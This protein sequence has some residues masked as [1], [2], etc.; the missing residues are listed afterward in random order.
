[1]YNNI[2]SNYTNGAYTF[3]TLVEAN[4]SGLVEPAY[5]SGLIRLMVNDVLAEKRFTNKFAQ[6]KKKRGYSGKIINSV[7]VNPANG[8]EFTVDG[9]TT[10]F[11]LAPADVKGSISKYT[12]PLQYDTTYNKDELMKAFTSESELTAFLN[13]IISSLY[14]GAE[15]DDKNEFIKL[16]SDLIEN[17]LVVYDEVETITTDSVKDLGI[18]LKK[19]V[20]KFK[21]ESDKY[22]VWKRVNPRDTHAIFWSNPEDINIILPISVWA[23]LDVALYATLFNMDK[24]DLSS[25][26]FTV[27]DDKLPEHVQAVIFDSTLINIEEI[28]SD[29]EPA[30]YDSSKRRFKEIYNVNN[31]YGVNPFAN[32]VVI[33]DDLA[34][35]PSIKASA[36]RNQTV[37]VE[38]GVKKTIVLDVVP[39]GAN[40]TIVPVP[41]ELT[42]TATVSYDEIE[43]W[44]MDITATAADAIT[45]TVDSSAITGTITVSVAE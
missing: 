44:T 6:F 42:T 5:L 20:A 18:A 39:V 36:V 43:G 11:D 41:G 37:V 1:M 45:F 19:Y 38:S 24:A 25:R 23:T 22:N 16:I 40:A 9:L 30:F 26:I 3:D 28:Y 12:K 29:L 7:Y 35:E 10:L 27:D 8:K 34:N 4:A 32:C 33:L 14:N 17:N 2:I 13:K 21:E 15:I 31:Q